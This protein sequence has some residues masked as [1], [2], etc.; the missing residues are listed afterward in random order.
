MMIDPAWERAHKAEKLRAKRR[1]VNELKVLAKDLGYKLV[2]NQHKNQE[3][4][5]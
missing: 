1:A 2:K 5:Q 4:K 3:V